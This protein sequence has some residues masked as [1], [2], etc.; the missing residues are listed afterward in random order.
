MSMTP[1]KTAEEKPAARLRL[2]LYILS[3]TAP[4]NA[5]LVNF[6]AIAEA[7]LVGRYEL[8][9][10]DVREEPLRALNEG[11]LMVPTLIVMS[12]E[13]NRV[14]VGDLSDTDAVLQVLGLSSCR[15]T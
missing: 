10:V 1:A 3:H 14:I 15:K 11:A 5:A 7:H 6:T 12:D 4:S 8:E 2:R 13:G 9:V